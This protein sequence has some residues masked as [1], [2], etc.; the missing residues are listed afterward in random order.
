[1][2]V[3]DF[4]TGHIQE[5]IDIIHTEI[6]DKIFDSHEFIRHFS[7]KFEIEY[8]SFLGQY[9]SAPFQYV[10]IQIGAF[11]ENNKAALGIIDLGKVYSQD[12]FGISSP[13]ENWQKV[14]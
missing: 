8:V 11:L 5:C 10:N 12:V 2:S 14:N 1:M 6:K 3:N 7:K 13:N 4:M 9:N